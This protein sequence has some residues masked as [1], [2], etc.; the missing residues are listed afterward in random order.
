MSHFVDGGVSEVATDGSNA[1]RVL[2]PGGLVGPWGLA[3]A[4]NGGL[5]IADGLS[6]ATLSAA[7]EVGR[8]GGLLDNS[9]P[10][11]V[12][13]MAA[14]ASGELLLATM[15]GDVVRYNPEALSFSYAIRK[16]RPAVWAGP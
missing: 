12:R 4:E 2:V 15:T 11:F 7:G 5:Y 6:L 16:T 3:C 1:E 8:L 14:G 13:G 9:F 10:G